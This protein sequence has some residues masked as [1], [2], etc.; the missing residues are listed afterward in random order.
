MTGKLVLVTGGARSGKSAYGEELARLQNDRVLY[1]A[2]AVAFDEEMKERIAI[3][4]QRRPA[5]W[6]TL[7]Q[8]RNL[9]EALSEI[10][11]SF[12][13]VLVDCLT[14]MT[15]NLM[16]DHSDV[17]WDKPTESVRNAVQNDALEQVDRLCRWILANEKTGILITNEVGMGIVPE[18][19][20][21]RFF[22]DV[23]GRVNQAA[24]ARA[25]EAWLVCCGI[26]LCLK[27]VA[28]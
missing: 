11:E 16:F 8:H 15:T 1:V 10:K 23:A 22:R 6:R 26:P 13:T 12:D 14:V 21:S 20:L 9:D 7:E 4:Q 3:H 18:N 24:A 5:E 17:D 2:T 19:A 27:P 25:T 28:P